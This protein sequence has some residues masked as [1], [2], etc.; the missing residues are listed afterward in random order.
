M[1]TNKISF[2][3]TADAG[4][5]YGPEAFTAVIGKTITIQLPDAVVAGV[6]V[7]ADVI[8]EGCAVMFTLDCDEAVARLVRPVSP[9]NMPYP[10]SVSP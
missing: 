9:V 1:T 8:E 6:V 3:I 4:S 10:Y 5:R 2:R 7:A